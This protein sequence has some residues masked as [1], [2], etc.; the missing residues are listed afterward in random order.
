VVTLS[1]SSAATLVGSISLLIGLAGMS[2]ACAGASLFGE[3]TSSDQPSS[4]AESATFSAEPIAP[5]PRLAL[6][7]RKGVDASGPEYRP[8]QYA[9]P[10]VARGTDRRDLYVGTDAGQVYCLRAGDGKTRWK[11]SFDEPIHA[12]P[13]VSDRQLVVAT[14]F[15]TLVGLNRSDGSTAW[16][17]D[18][19]SGIDTPPET[20]RGL[21]VVTTVAE[22][23]I[24]I[25]R[26]TGDKAWSY[27]R[28]KPQKFT[29]KGGGRPTIQNKTAY[30]GFSDGYLVALNM[31]SGEP[32]WTADLSADNKEYVDIVARPRVHGGRV[33][34]VSYANGV[35][36][37][38]TNDGGI[39][40]RRPFENVS[41]LELTSDTTYLTIATGRV[42]AVDTE[43][44]DTKWGF[45]M[46]D[47]LPVGLSQAG[48]YLFV[49][50]SSGPLYV[51]DR[52]SGYPFERWRPSNGFGT[53]VAF[54]TNAGYALS[55]GGYLYR[56]RLAF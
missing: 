22:T 26:Q 14:T 30:V 3:P 34:A 44:G 1:R 6:E 2:S 45:S 33:Y 8:R 49:S 51:L 31:L 4:K 40:W 28:Q 24:A 37:L 32:R 53:S 9:D 25:D 10:V 18:V 46:T 23:V 39:I 11:R 50:T 42:V 12:A 52:Q 38:D 48:P 36:A 35:Y 15:G 13:A 5:A 16:R 7:W 20:G 56:F 17:F 27:S 19:E 41:D 43:S 54:S 55:N 21:A 29:V 47:N